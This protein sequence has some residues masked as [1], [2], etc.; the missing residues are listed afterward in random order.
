MCVYIC[1]LYIFLKDPTQYQVKSQRSH[2]PYSLPTRT[3]EN[4]RNNPSGLK[5]TK[6]HRQTD[7]LHQSILKNAK[8]G[9]GKMDDLT[10]W[11]LYT[12]YRHIEKEKNRACIYIHTSRHTILWLT[13][14]LIFATARLAVW[15]GR[16]HS[17]LN[18]PRCAGTFIFFWL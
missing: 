16:P 2:Y 15:L 3:N 6:Y 4:V 8:E 11:R 7:L 1:L 14:K 10:T 12:T 13:Y 9:K 17:S 5:L 18:V